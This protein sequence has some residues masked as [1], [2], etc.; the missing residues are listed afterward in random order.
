MTQTFFIFPNQLYEDISVLKNYTNIILLEEPIYFHDPEWRPIRPHKIKIA[1]MRACM[2]NYHKML[3]KNG[4]K[5]SYIDYKT[6]LDKKGFYD[7]DIVCYEF[8]DHA[9]R[10]KLTKLCNN[11]TILPTANFLMK[12]QDLQEYEALH[13]SPRHASF[14]EFVKTKLNVLKG[15]KSQDMLNRQ[16][17][18]TNPNNSRSED[19]FNKGV[20]KSIYDEAISYSESPIFS[21]HGGQATELGVY[22]INHK[23]SYKSLDNFFFTRFVDY[24]PYQDSIVENNPFMYHTVISPMLNIGLLDPQK[25]LGMILKQQ[26]PLN[27]LEG[28]VRQLIGWREYMRYVYVMKYNLIRDA[29][30]PQNDMTFKTWTPWY[31]GTTGV[32]PLDQ[33][34]K[35][36]IKYG[37]AHHIIRLMIFMNFFI[38]CEIHPDEI[39]KWFMEVVSI[40]AYDWVMISNIYAMGYFDKGAM[41]KPYI[42][43]SNYVLKMSNYK[44]DGKWDVIWTELFYRFIAKKPSSYVG[45]YK[46]LLKGDKPTSNAD[47]FLTEFTKKLK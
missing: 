32:Y 11:L 47:N 41:R 35:K 24:G 16:P 30:L 39:Y 38:L 26:V 45:F 22:P 43:T 37:Y 6:A 33:E 20:L 27:S 19:R 36:A 5:A 31:N 9:L 14:Y 44:K 21:Q 1:Y 40:D 12:M 15:I 42:T 8:T 23:D 29:N 2:K 34:I 28:L 18:P 3:L 10:K 7:C 4:I 13:K 46:R 17:P 25:V